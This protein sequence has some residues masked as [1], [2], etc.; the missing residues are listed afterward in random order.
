MAIAIDAVSNSGALQTVASATYSHTI[1]AANELLVVGGAGRTSD[2]NK[3]NL[4]ITGV[5]YNGVAL[6]S[7]KATQQDSTGA[8]FR[9]ELWYIYNPS[10]GANNVVVTWTG[11]L[12]YGGS[13]AAS[14]SGVATSSPIESSGGATDTTLTTLTGP[15]RVGQTTNAMVDCVYSR[16]G[17][18]TKDASQTLIAGIT[19]ASDDNVGMSYK[20]NAT[21][22]LQ[23]MVWTESAD[24]NDWSITVASI[25][26]PPINN[27]NNFEFIKAGNGMSASEKIK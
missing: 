19:I 17:T 5:T 12:V 13:A 1:A 3:A 24:G 26:A 9:S 15:V 8:S 6:T 10:T 23:N 21:G 11:T 27:L 14:F 25:S 2:V 4:V 7:I 22:G 16:S 18:L 20:L